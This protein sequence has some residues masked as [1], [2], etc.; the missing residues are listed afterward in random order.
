MQYLSKVLITVGCFG[1]FVGLLGCR[2]PDKGA[3]KIGP[4]KK[5]GVFVG[6]RVHST[7]TV[8]SEGN[9][10]VG[11]SDHHLYAFK[12]NGRFLWKYKAKGMV[13]VWSPS[14]GPDG[15]VAFAT[16]D[17]QLVVLDSDGRLRWSHHPRKK[18][19][20]CAPIITQGMVI[21]TGDLVLI[22]YDLKTGKG[23]P[24]G[25]K[26]PPIKG[27]VSKSPTGD[28]YFS[29]HNTLFAW[30][31]EKQKLTLLW[32]K[33]YKTPWN[34][35]GFD[36]KGNLYIGTQKGRLFS[37]TPQGKE[38]W[39]FQAPK[40]QESKG[41]YGI[42]GVFARPVVSPKG[43]VLAFRLGDGIYA[44]SQDKGKKLW[45]FPEGER[46]FNGY[47]T[48]AKN[49]MIYAGSFDYHMYA[50]TPEGKEHYRFFTNDRISFGATLSPDG[51]TLY[52]G[53][54][55]KHFY[56]LHTQKQKKK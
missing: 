10:Y 3:G 30:K 5:W 45:V 23:T 48:V 47:L 7:P 18:M 54:E 14:V 2:A 39:S 25:K 1:F 38:R 29:N 52:I 17:G 15:S 19:V 21:T 6:D 49:G 55:D 11:S 26:F 9:V 50:I 34:L 8:D 33:K 46:P 28:I 53:S 20:G 42:N 32:K 44:L 40:Q 22:A 36:Q 31:L 56:A 43:Q 51:K 13:K 37:L 4:V 35:P 16:S 27:C 24:L 12:A 41:L